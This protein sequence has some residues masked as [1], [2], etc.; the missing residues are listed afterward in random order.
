M[1]LDFSVKGSDFINIDGCAHKI[2]VIESVSG[3]HPIAEFFG[4]DKQDDAIGREYFTTLNDM[5]DVFN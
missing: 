4:R 3:C 2:G 1:D 5:G